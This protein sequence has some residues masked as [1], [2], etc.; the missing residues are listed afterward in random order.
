M[1][2]VDESSLTGESLPAEKYPGQMI[3]SGSAMK[4]GEVKN[5]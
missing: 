2:T 1:I 3:L 5:L 4:T